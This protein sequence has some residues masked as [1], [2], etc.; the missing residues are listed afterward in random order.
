MGGKGTRTRPWQWG[1]INLLEGV[2][3]EM[4]EI[5]RQAGEKTIRA[6][7]RPLAYLAGG[8]RSHAASGRLIYRFDAAAAA[9]LRRRS[10]LLLRRRTRRMRREREREG[11]VG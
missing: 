10:S 11:G 9:A 1:E 7:A 8:L 5:S 6:S 3:E 2:E 4:K